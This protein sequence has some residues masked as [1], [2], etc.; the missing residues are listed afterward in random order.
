MESSTVQV[1]RDPQQS[2]KLCREFAVLFMRIRKLLAESVK[3]HDLIDFLEGYS[4][5]LYPEE[6]YVNPKVFVNA[7]TTDELLKSLFPKHINYIHYYLLDDIV[8]V[9]G[10][11]ESKK[12]LK[13]Y[14]HLMSK[15]HKLDHMPDPISD[16]EIEQSVGTKRLKIEVDTTEGT[17]SLVESIQRSLEKV[18]GIRKSSIV[19]A[20]QDPG[21]VILTFL[22]PEGVSH[23]F[24]ELN[25]EDLETLA[26]AGV[27][28]LQMESFVLNSIQLYVSDRFKRECDTKSSYLQQHLQ[29]RRGELS[30]ERYFHL[31]ELLQ[32]LP[33]KELD[34]ICSKKFL[35]SLA[36][37]VTDWKGLALGLGLLEQEVEDIM[38]QWQ[39]EYSQMCSAFMTWKE[40]ECDFA[41]YHNLLG[42]ILQHGSIEEV[43]VM[44]QSLG[45]GTFSCS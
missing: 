18:S 28:K 11:S 22:I 19:Y 1:H 30:P 7:C 45:P 14:K 4:H 43:G 12:A 35:A 13:G 34:T 32:A 29:E 44:L 9:F 6:Q 33:I 25:S 23:V 31:L 15:K 16:E 27:M 8:E 20:C 42:C 3:V 37:D 26:N 38:A 39:D 10:C 24:I 36:E 17:V 5:P 40:K 21:S 2:H 41:T